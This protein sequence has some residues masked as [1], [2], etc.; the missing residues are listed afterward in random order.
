MKHLKKSKYL[1]IYILSFSIPLVVAFI[2]LILGRF[3][4][5]GD[6]FTLIA[7]NSSD[8][9]PFY[10]KLHDAVHSGGSWTFT[11][12]TDPTN[13]LILLF[14]KQLIPTILNLL[15]AFKIAVAGLAMS[16][17]LCHK[18]SLITDNKEPLT[19]KEETN[20][21]DSNN[22][23]NIVIGFKGVPKTTIGK[24][25]LNTNW[26]IVGISAAYA[27]SITMLTIGMNVAFTS[28]IAI[29]PLVIYGI[30]R[31]VANNNPAIFIIFYTLSIICNLH[32]AIIT[33]IFTLLYFF[34]RDFHDSLCFVKAIRN[35]IIGLILSLMCG[36][37]VLCCSY[38]NNLFREDLSLTFP[39][40]KAINPL[41]LVNQL[42]T[43]NTLS[44]YSLYDNFLDIAF[45]VGFVFFIFLYLFVSKIEV[46]TKI[47]N[48]TLFLFLFLGTSTTTFRHL[49]NGLSVS[50]GTSVHYGYLIVFMGLLL[51]YESLSNIDILKVR[52]CITAGLL[53]TALIIATMLFSTKYDNFS[54]YIVSLEF[55]FGFFIMTL[56]YSSKSLTKSL[57]K[58]LF[59]LILFF[60][61]I[62]NYTKNFKTIGTYY[63]SQSLFRNKEYQTYEAERILHKE[64]PNAII[65]YYKSGES[66]ETPFTSSLSGIDYFI[67]NIELSDSY[68]DYYGFYSPNNGNNGV[69]IYK[70]KYSL[71]NA[72]YD[73]SI[74]DYVYDKTKPFSSASIFTDTYL[75]SGEIFQTGD[76][77][78]HY[79]ESVD[80]SSIQFEIL[81]YIGGDLYIKAFSVNHLGEYEAYEVLYATQLRPQTIFPN[82]YGDYELGAF[83]EE[84]LNKIYTEHATR[85]DSFIDNENTVEAKSDG[86]FSV[87]TTVDPSLNYYVNGEKVTPISLVNNAALV[88]VKAGTNTIKI[89]YNPIYLIIGLIFTIIGLV[90]SFVYIKKKLYNKEHVY[91]KRLADHFRVNYV[92]YIVFA[93]ITILFILCQM[94]TSSYPFG[95]N[96]T[97]TGD[98]LSQGYPS[99]VGQINDVKEGKPFFFVNYDVGG[100]MDMYHATL[101]NITMPWI[102]I[103]YLFL[104]ESL[105]LLDYTLRYLFNLLIAG[106]AIIFYLTHRE[107]NRYA[108]SDKKL[109]VIGLMYSISTYMAVFYNYELLRFG[110]YL[111]LIILGMEKLIYHNKKALYIITMFFMMIYDPYHTFLLCEFLALYFFTMNFSSVKDFFIKGIRF[112]LSSI[113]SAGLAAFSI[114]SYFLFTQSSGY[115]KQT[116]ETPLIGNWFKN[117]LTFMTDYRVNNVFGSTSE[118]RS[119]AAI[120]AGL[121][122]LFVLPLYAICKKVKLNERIRII[123]LILLLYISFDNELLNFIF[124]GFHM[125]SLVPNRYAVFF[126]FLMVSILATI[127]KNIKEYKPSHLQLTVIC[128]SFIYILLYVANRDIS[129]LSLITTVIFMVIYVLLIIVYT[130]KKLDNTKLIRYML[131]FTA[132]EII[133]NFTVV[134]SNQISGT[135]EMITEAKKID[136][137]SDAVPDTKEFY[138]LTEYLGYH[139]LYYNIGAMT[140]I[141]T[142][143]YFASSYTYDMSDR[144]E[145]Y[146]LPYGANSMDYHCGNPLADMMLDIKYHIEDRYDDSAFSIYDKIYTYN[147]YNLYQNPYHIPLGFVTEN[148]E[149]INDIKL[150]DYENNETFDYQNNLATALGGESFYEQLDLEEYTEG[151][152]EISN[153][154]VYSYGEPYKY[155]RDNSQVVDYIPIYIRLSDEINGKIYAA[156]EGR[157]YCIGEVGDNNHELTLDYSLED[158]MKDDFKPSIALF[159]E[160]S[161]S[162]LYN[163]LSQNK[164]SD[165]SEDGQNIYAK[166]DTGVSGK[167]YI[168]LPYDEAWVVYI[169]DKKVEKERYLGGIGVNVEA[170]SHTLRM[171][172]HPV[173]AWIGIAISITTL[174]IIILCSLVSYKLKHNDKEEILTND[175][176]AI[177]ESES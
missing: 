32:I 143:S 58:I 126:V 139:P 121:I 34:T 149:T 74:K 48:F 166:L 64:E 124:H 154:S 2:G 37:V 153:K 115:V 107:N 70:N 144:I 88:P 75:H 47:K 155:E 152:E 106:F 77:E 110:F 26:I 7:S 123:A 156:V 157:I 112:A 27:L 9:L 12:I 60:E 46:S 138:N 164:L 56:V 120:Y 65:S 87:G 35:Y 17:F 85:N 111:P 129:K 151:D 142:L 104:P 4:P 177:T 50:A 168:S 109:I 25:L 13:L 28:A 113:A 57:F 31:I 93:T 63:I 101:Y 125:Q 171:E 161:F 80:G 130:I 174:I 105:Y 53:T 92:Y 170:G 108:I 131:A 133:I 84:V 173:G 20:T 91:I 146:N 73:S 6:K 148:S 119:Q 98:A 141:H 1:T 49:F 69:Y 81:P 33:G 162:K 5:F 8:Y 82:E 43:K 3:E 51:S 42:M 61:I 71:R 11:N 59:V 30:D 55:I 99:I 83:N 134:F 163:K 24:F 169:D 95:S 72:F 16:I 147:N 137:I 79:M 78:V 175:T 23:K 116:V 158:V 172:F 21:K 19:V 117:F 54:S 15:Y 102:F 36:G 22:K 176:E 40:F 18:A 66:F 89:T 167:L 103:K 76:K 97:L 160:E 100:F 68:L 165:I 122:I 159:N 118:N 140:D 62:P 45:G 114:Y 14:S 150:K 44:M 135:S 128:I 96:P 94:I 127:I 86:Y 136:T 132:L 38:G 145:H 41:N 67:S 10:Y 52:N 39:V 90:L 29:L